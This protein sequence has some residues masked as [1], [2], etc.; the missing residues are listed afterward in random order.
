MDKKPE[1]VERW[2]WCDVMDAYV[3]TPEGGYVLAAYYS[4]LVAE[5][6]GWKQQVMD[7]LSANLAFR[8]AGGAKPDEDMPTFCARL[9]AERDAL[10]EEF[11]EALRSATNA[12]VYELN[13]AEALREDA[14]RYRWLR[15]RSV[16]FDPNDDGK[17]TPYCVYGLGMGDTSPTF[18]TELD[19][20]VDASRSA[21]AAINAARRGDG[22]G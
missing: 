16:N 13:R 18:G 1:P 7:E 10:R 3:N 2:E 19:A 6:D 11:G 8:E 12:Y 9:I 17:G 15:D 22:R 4:A 14:E 20:M 21:D 5:R